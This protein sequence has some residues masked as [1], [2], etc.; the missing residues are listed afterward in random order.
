MY[1]YIFRQRKLQETLLAVQQL[2][3]SMSNLRKWLVDM[4]NELSAPLVYKE[5]ERRDIQN[6]LGHQSVSPDLGEI[7]HFI[8]HCKT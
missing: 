2:D 3:V 7:F 6:K 4:E 1:S 5:C 8:K